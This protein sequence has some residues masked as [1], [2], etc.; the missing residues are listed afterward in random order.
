MPGD[1]R[2]P[3]LLV[4]AVV[5]G[6]ASR[7]GAQAHAL[8]PILAATAPLTH[9]AVASGRAFRPSAFEAATATS[10]TRATRATSR[11]TEETPFP[12]GQMD[13]IPNQVQPVSPRTAESTN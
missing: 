8:P 7:P 2:E 4:D 6:L 13:L 9:A 12:I 3:M 1:T 5:R 11:F 10:T